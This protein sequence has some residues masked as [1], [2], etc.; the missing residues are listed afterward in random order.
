MTQLM[1]TGRHTGKKDQQPD[2]AKAKDK[3]KIT[4]AD[5]VA[6]VFRSRCGTCHNPDKA[7]GGLGRSSANN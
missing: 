3:E 2:D 4:Y 1:A 7:K 5:H 6:G